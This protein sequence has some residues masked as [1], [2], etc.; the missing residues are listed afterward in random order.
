MNQDDKKQ[1]AAEKALSLIPKGSYIG[2]G[3]GSTVNFLID[4]LARTKFDIKGAVATSL[5]TERRLTAAGITVVTPAEAGRLPVYIDG[6]DEINHSLQMIK[7]GGGA[8]LREKVVASI[9]D[10]FICIADDTKYVSKLGKFPLP[11]EVLPFA[12]SIVAK[13]LFRMGGEANLR[14][15]FKT[16]GGHEILDVTGLDLSRPLTMEDE[17]NKIVGVMDNGIFARNAANVL[18]LGTNHGAELISAK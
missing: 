1:A 11:V 14:V 9:S 18:V 5:D 15:G 17:L 16:D 8:L 2:V 13:A 12:R 10:T 4:A 3:T 6:A 7:G